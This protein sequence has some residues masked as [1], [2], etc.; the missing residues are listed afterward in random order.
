MWTINGERGQKRKKRN[1][2]QNPTSRAVEPFPEPPRTSPF[3]EKGLEKPKENDKCHF[4]RD[5]KWD[6]GALC[7]PRIYIYKTCYYNCYELCVQKKNIL[8]FVFLSLSVSLFSL[9]LCVIRKILIRTKVVF[10][11]K[12]NIVHFCIRENKTKFLNHSPRITHSIKYHIFGGISFKL[13]HLSL[14]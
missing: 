13:N 9:S 4:G 10:K 5:Y 2:E 11:Y 3:R 1:S 12:R 7:A 8:S 14:V 6:Y